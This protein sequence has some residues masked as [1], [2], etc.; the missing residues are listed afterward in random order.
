MSEVYLKPDQIRTSWKEVKVKARYWYS[1]PSHTRRLK[2][3]EPVEE[4]VEWL[5][6]NVEHKKKWKF[7]PSTKSIVFVSEDDAFHFRM[8]W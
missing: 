7:H 3:I 5:T 6:K 4:I 1:P 2:R 8:R